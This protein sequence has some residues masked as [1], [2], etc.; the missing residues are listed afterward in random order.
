MMRIVCFFRRLMLPSIVNVNTL[1]RYNH[2][3]NLT[4][5]LVFFAV[6]RKEKKRTSYQGVVTEGPVGSVPNPGKCQYRPFNLYK[7]KGYQWAC[8]W[9]NTRPRPPNQCLYNPNYTQVVLSLHVYRKERTFI[10]LFLWYID[11]HA[12]TDR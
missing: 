9:P 1:C 12:R 6:Q 11:T 3:F 4:S 5:L 10:L 8:L 2:L 7:I